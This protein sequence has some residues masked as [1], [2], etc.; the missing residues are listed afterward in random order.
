[1]A[2]NY[3]ERA[4]MTIRTMVPVSNPRRKKR[5]MK[6]RNPSHVALA[7]PG[8]R[9]VFETT[10]G[11]LVKGVL[12]RM[13]GTKLVLKV[14]ASSNGYDKGEEFTSSGNFIHPAKNV[15]VKGGAYYV[16]PVEWVASKTNP[17]RK[18]RAMPTKRKTT[19]RR[20]RRNPDEAR[21]EKKTPWRKFKF[22]YEVPKKVLK[23][24]FDYLDDAETE[25]G[26][27]KYLNQWYHTSEF[28][29]TQIPGWDGIAGD[30]AFS[31]TLLKVSSDG[32]RYKA[33]RIYS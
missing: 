14:T 26:F 9:V 3:F 30:S 31:G 7:K 15:R 6:R 18:K 28:M 2:P 17:R 32:E 33:A 24:Q 22:G 10:Q 20:T 27:F 8:T 25:D 11:G 16:T 5:T 29:R 4:P 12:V 21:I 19:K 13:S 23:D 1:M